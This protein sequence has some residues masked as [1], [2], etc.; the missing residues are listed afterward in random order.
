MTNE[1]KKGITIGADPELFIHLD[2][3]VIP[4]VGLLGGTKES[5]ANV[6]DGIYVQ[7]DNVMAEYNIPPCTRES[8]F[9][10][11]NHNAIRKIENILPEGFK[12][13]VKTSHIFDES[14]LEDPQA[15]EVGCAPDYSAYL[16]KL[17]PR[18]NSMILKGVRSC[19][20]HLHFGYDKPTADQNYE[21]VKWL[22]LYVGLHN[23][24]FDKD[25]TRR[26]FYGQAGSMRHKPYGFEYR[27]PSNY[28][29]ESDE[30]MSEVFN[31]AKA[32]M[33][34]SLSSKMDERVSHQVRQAIDDHNVKLAKQLH[35][36]YVKE[37]VIA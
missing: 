20:G 1:K 28:W 37:V 27:T 36:A 2:G 17:K 10:E 33:E 13:L 7:E 11:H 16:K 19:S 14:M 32:G 8:E 21:S 12:T 24:M 29:L 5:P 31:L 4:V 6:G 22:D 23:V 26:K 30:L 15:R 35:K 34:R 18:I 3:T 9:I 25:T